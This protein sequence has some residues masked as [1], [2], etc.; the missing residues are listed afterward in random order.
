[1]TMPQIH[2]PMTTLTPCAAPRTP[3]PHPALY[4]VTCAGEELEVVK[5][6]KFWGQG[7]EVLGPVG[8]EDCGLPFGDLEFLLDRER[9]ERF[10]PRQG[11]QVP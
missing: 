2:A 5:R 9:A 4:Q 10:G 8:P 7:D 3:F 11:G 6:N 1:M